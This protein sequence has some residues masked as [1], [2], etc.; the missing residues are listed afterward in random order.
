MALIKKVKLGQ[1]QVEFHID[2]IPTNE[3]IRNRLI[4]IYDVINNIAV[5]AEKRGVDTSKWFYTP[6]QIKSLK[7]TNGNL[8]V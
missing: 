2:E 4:K 1:A 8:F 5:A 7:E 3:Q 6:K